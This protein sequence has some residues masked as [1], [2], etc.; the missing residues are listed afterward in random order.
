MK[1]AERRISPF[2]VMEISSFTADSVCSDVFI[3]SVRH[4]EMSP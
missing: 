1:P 4:A 2:S 3:Y